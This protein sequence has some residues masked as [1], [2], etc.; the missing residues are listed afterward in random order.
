MGAAAVM[1]A[2]PPMPKSNL[3][4]VYSHY[5]RIAEAVDIDIV[6]QDYPKTTGVHMPPEFFMRLAD[7]IP[8]V[9]YC[10]IEAPPTPPKVRAIK[11]LAGRQA[12]N[13][14]RA[15][16]LFLLDE[17]A[18]GGA[19]AM[20]GFASPGD[21]GQDLPPHRGGR[22]RGRGKALLRM[23]APDPVR[24]AGGDR[25][26]HPQERTSLPGPAREPGRA[27]TR[28][29]CRRSNHQAANRAH[30]ADGVLE[31]LVRNEAAL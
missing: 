13:F 20:T 31:S 24:G 16:R 21:T 26:Q 25:P 30:R 17:L 8:A 9:Q 10:K 6:V 27:T 11:A 23:A 14:R 28:D 7:D 29:P 5:Y 15:G 4:V 19:G 18:Q 12:D 1:I 3:D 22:D 2:P